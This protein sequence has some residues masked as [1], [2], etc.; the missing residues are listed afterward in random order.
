MKK[1]V[2]LIASITVFIQSYSAIIHTDLNPDFQTTI[3][4][5]A[6]SANNLINIDFNG[7]G[8]KEYDIRWD[9]N[10]T[11]GWFLHLV[12]EGNNE[13]FLTGQSNPY[14]GKYIKV[15]NENEDIASLSWGEWGNSIP[16]PLIGDN[17]YGSFLTVNGDDKFIAVKFILNSNTHYGWIKVALN[18]QYQFF[19]KEYAYND[20]PN[21][22]ILAGETGQSQN[23]QIT[24]INVYGQ[25][26]A[27]SVNEGQSVQMEA[28]ILP[29]NATNQNLIWSV[30][31]GTGSATINSNGNLIGQTV[32]E[33]TVKASA[34][35]FSN[36]FGEAVMTITS[37][38]PI[39]VSSID[40]I[41]YLGVTDI[42]IN[43]TLQLNAIIQPNNASNL[44]V[45]WSIVNGTGSA[46]I[47]SSGLLT[48][49][50][51]GTVTAYATANDGTN[52]FDSLQITIKPILAN[53]I[54]I[55]SS[56]GDEVAETQ[57]IQLNATVLPNNT[58]NQ[59]VNWTVVNGTGTATIN[60]SGLLT[61]QTIGDVD[62]MA[63]TTDGSNIS[64]TLKVTVIELIIYVSSIEV[65]GENNQTNVPL[66]Q[67]LQMQANILPTNATNTNFDW[68][69][70][71][72]TGTATIDNSGLLSPT[73]VGNVTVKAV[74]QDGSN[75][76]GEKEITITEV[77]GVEE[78]EL[79]A[80][81]VYPNPSS[82][83]F[84][85]IESTNQIQTLRIL[86]LA[87]ELVK[88]EKFSNRIIDISELKNGIYIIELLNTDLSKEYHQLIKN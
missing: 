47:N 86:S 6:F 69:I 37:S 65:K 72:G 30:T 59:N 10:L 36:V 2:L 75:V 38:A 8:V 16:E 43:E 9:A 22:T 46:T 71:N 79:F 74:A 85:Q 88:R 63:T 39:N 83:G 64:D 45:S 56:S 60:S 77:V 42:F 87:G 78:T 23:I 68:F 5:N 25:N 19:I 21:G 11:Q 31:N 12:H 73:S 32:G 13:V 17:D 61:G 4:F 41:A 44:S 27:V 26:G 20:V 29:Q 33:V 54:S 24:S 80:S 62:V 15:I 57:S 18:N 14:G 35:D 67:N 84:I 3:D 52:I 50:T 58:T 53:S 82:D 40:V 1:I 34:T 49:T 81:S 7:D 70:L 66:N 55:S 51:V 28:S 48:P 76:S